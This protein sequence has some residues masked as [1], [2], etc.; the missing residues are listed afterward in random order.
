MEFQKWLAV[1]F[2][3]YAGKRIIRVCKAFATRRQAGLNLKKVGIECRAIGRKLCARL[4]NLAND[5]RSWWPC[6][7][8][9]P[10]GGEKEL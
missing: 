8:N 2:A 7:C 5:G 4:N 1:Y 3:L 10:H 6:L 9:Y